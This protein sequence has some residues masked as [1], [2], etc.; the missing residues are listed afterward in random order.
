MTL[1]VAFALVALLIPDARAESFCVESDADDYSPGS[2]FATFDQTAEGE[3]DG[4][5]GISLPD[6]DA[7][8]QYWIVAEVRFGDQ[9]FSWMEGPFEGEPGE[10]AEWVPEVPPAALMSDEQYDYL[11]DLVVSVELFSEHLAYTVTGAGYARLA[12]DPGPKPLVMMPD[13]AAALAPGDAWT[14]EAE[15]RVR[16]VNIADVAR[17]PPPM[18]EDRGPHSEEVDG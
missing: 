7:T 1:P 5:V 16:R 8:L 9:Q 11:S 6:G 2:F 12:F 17:P 14:S 3:F 10:Y 18:D 13:E 4:A 15:S